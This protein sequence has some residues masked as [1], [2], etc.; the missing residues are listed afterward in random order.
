MKLQI[1]ISLIEIQKVN[2]IL[3][4]MA[5]KSKNL[6]NNLMDII[7]L[8]ENHYIKKLIMD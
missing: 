4:K 2:Y 6:Q 3:I 8:L 1:I 5:I 7:Q